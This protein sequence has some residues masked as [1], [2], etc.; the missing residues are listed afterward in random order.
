MRRERDNQ[1]SNER[2]H[3]ALLGADRGRSGARAAGTARA[4]DLGGGR[5]HGRGAAAM[6]RLSTQ[7]RFGSVHRLSRP[8][9]H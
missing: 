2:R 9:T 1:D 6:A 4:E 7:A 8:I 5:A 3:A